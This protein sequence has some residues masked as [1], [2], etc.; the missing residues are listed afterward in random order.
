M[1]DI[2]PLFATAP[3]LKIRIQESLVAYAVGFNIA[4]SVDVQPIF[5]I[6]SYAP[7]SLEPTLYN[8]VTGTMQIVR[9][10]SKETL[11]KKAARHQGGALAF[12]GVDGNELTGSAPDTGSGSNSPL[13]QKELFKHIDPE[14]LLLSRSFN[15]DIYMKV[16]NDTHTGLVEKS[17]MKIVDCRITSRNT[18]IAMGQLV[19]EP[20]SFQ[21][22]LAT[23]SRSDD[24]KFSL[25]GFVGQKDTSVGE[26]G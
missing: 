3:R 14:K 12:T 19:N 21:G 7:V 24:D 5:V 17:W 4:V 22:L 18:N 20:V 23:P 8:T 11:A 2:M 9:L 1:S 16:P 15:T 25:D 10:L 6:G 26:E 13:E